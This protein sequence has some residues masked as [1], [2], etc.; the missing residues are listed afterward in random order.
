[1]RRSLLALA[2]LTAACSAT[3]PSQRRNRRATRKKNGALFVS[4]PV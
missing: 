1:M 4:A 2:T 3:N